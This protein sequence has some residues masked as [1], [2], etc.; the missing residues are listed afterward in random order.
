MATK[1]TK[2]QWIEILLNRELTIE[3]DLSILQ[4]LYAFEGHKAYAS[5]IG[6]ILGYKGKSP[7]GPLNLEIGRYAKRIAKYYDIEFTERSNRKYK[8]WDLFFNG[9]GDGKYFVWQMKPDL[10]EA[11][12][13][14]E[15]TGELQFA[16]ELPIDALE[17]LTE[18]IKRTVIINSYERN[19]KA[20]QLC[21]EYWGFSCS[22]CE[23]DF[24]KLY[25]EI[26]KGFIHVHHLIPVSQIGKLYQ[27]NPI[28]DL[29]PV[30]PNCHSMLHKQNPPLK[31][32]ELKNMIDRKNK[33]PAAH[34]VL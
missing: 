1:L 19:P 6:V 23:I 18:G 11:L 21:V 4:A 9:W 28:K 27:I 13:K 31:I 3:L 5:Q 14:S 8:F 2:T 30:C 22:V 32:E 15:L 20:R 12:K 17:E 26:G 25:G 34:C 33:Y 24:E 7:H 29:R 16:D 10:V